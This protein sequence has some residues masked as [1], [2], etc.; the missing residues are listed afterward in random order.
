MLFLCLSDLDQVALTCLT[1]PR[2]A[3]ASGLL[4]SVVWRCLLPRRAVGGKC[5]GTLLG[6]KDIPW[7]QAKPGAAPHTRREEEYGGT[8]SHRPHPFT[9]THTVCALETHQAQHIHV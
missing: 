7:P 3:E 6:R 2:L 5:E 8:Q 4:A 1:G 9:H